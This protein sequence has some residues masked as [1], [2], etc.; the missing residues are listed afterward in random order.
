MYADVG[1]KFH[2]I[3]GGGIEAVHQAQKQEGGN[4]VFLY[5]AATEET[6]G[7]IKGAYGNIN[8]ILMFKDGSGFVTAGEEGIVRVYR[9]DES[10]YAETD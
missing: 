5:D 4:Q 9:F 7:T 10:Y 1:K 2:L 6:I 8:W 3:F